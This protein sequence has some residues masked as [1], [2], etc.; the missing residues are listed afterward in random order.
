MRTSLPTSGDCQ[1][2]R[3]GCG[4]RLVRMGRLVAL[5]RTAHAAPAVAVTCGTS[6]LALSAG[7]GPRTALFGLAVASGQL[8]VG[9]SN[10][11][12]DRD[13]DRRAHRSDKPIVSGLIDARTVAKA[14]AIA[15]GT[16]V[17]LSLALG[18][19]P[20]CAHLVAVGS[21]WAYNGWL[22]TTALSV[23]PY[24]LSFGAIPGVVT[25]GLPAA[26]LPPWW[27]VLAAA[28]LGSGAHLLNGA[29]DIDVDTMIGVRSLPQMLGERTAL[30]V[31]VSCMLVATLLLVAGPGTRVGGFV[32]LVAAA[33]VVTMIAI[34]AAFATKHGRAGWHL[35][36]VTG[37]LNAALLVARGDALG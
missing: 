6:A 29:R 2:R 35:V 8:S 27:A 19:R 16:C 32:W 11:F 14:A 30:A 25:L 37:L 20:G 26:P 24:A 22:K 10:D 31:G 33:I 18:W 5:I 23:V 7:W 36:L 15:L 28:A 17:A 4:D 21:G 3:A 1:T 12:V 9:W 34:L 13:V